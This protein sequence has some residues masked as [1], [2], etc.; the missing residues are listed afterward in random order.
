MTIS[1]GNWQ[2]AEFSEDEK[3]RSLG[4]QLIRLGRDDNTKTKAEILPPVKIEPF[5]KEFIRKSP[6]TIL[7]YPYEALTDE[8]DYLQ[9][10]IRE[11][12]PVKSISKKKGLT[13]DGSIR[14]NE[15]SY[16]TTDGKNIRS[17]NKVSELTTTELNKTKK[18]LNAKG[19]I[20]LPIPSNVQDANSVSYSEG[21]LDEITSYIYTNLASNVTSNTTPAGGQGTNAFTQI[22]SQLSTKVGVIGK[23]LLTDSK[24]KQLLA[25]NL[26][27]QAANIPLGSSLTRDQVIARSSGQVL[28]QNVELLFNGVTLRSFKFSFKF[29]P[30][31]PDEADQ[32][33]YII[34][35]LKL[36]MAAK[37]SEG[38]LFLSTPNVFELT[39]KKGN[40]PH[41]FLNNFKQCVLTDM[42]INYTGEGTYVVYS[43]A[44]PVSMILELGFK[45]LEPI[46]D[47]DYDDEFLPGVGY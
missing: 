38:N 35:S 19:S 11:Y 47:L 8:T 44:T 33:Y 4:G 40:G 22:A 26:F 13:S 1:I 24:Y 32:V 16:E 41:P 2:D 37:V 14:Q 27:A 3:N 18:I 39:Y 29:T 42:S 10:D 21:K 36:N 25:T 31:N 12:N 34:E 5:G 23:T 7:R 9:I 6:G 46:Y 17:G 28:N 45:E 15:I 20:L 30:R 43:D